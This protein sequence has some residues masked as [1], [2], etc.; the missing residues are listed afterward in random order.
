[1]GGLL[2]AVECGVLIGK[3]ARI[4]KPP[5][6]IIRMKTSSGKTVITTSEQTFVR[7]GDGTYGLCKSYH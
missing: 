2:I 4:E 5:S 1:M 7:G 6:A 3:R